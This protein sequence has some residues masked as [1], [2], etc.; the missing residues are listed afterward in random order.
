MA[1]RV[2]SSPYTPP[3]TTAGA[4]EGSRQKNL[5][6]KIAKIQL[7]DYNP[8]SYEFSDKTKDKELCIAFYMSQANAYIEAIRKNDLTKASDT[9]QAALDA[10]QEKE[11][12]NL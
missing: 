4:P 6:E 10:T 11:T 9:F 5:S 12:E 1:Q 8:K 2:T 7:D 3:T